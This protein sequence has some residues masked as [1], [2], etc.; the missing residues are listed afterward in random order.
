MNSIKNENNDSQ[1]ENCVILL[2][3]LITEKTNVLIFLYNL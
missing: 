1:I 2:F 3:G